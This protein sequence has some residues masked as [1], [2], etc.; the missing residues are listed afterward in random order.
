MTGLSVFKGAEAHPRFLERHHPEYL[1]APPQN[2]ELEAYATDSL[3]HEHFQIPPGW[4]GIDGWASNRVVVDFGKSHHGSELLPDEEEAFGPA[5]VFRN[6][7]LV[8]II[9][10]TG[11][12]H[13]PPSLS[14]AFM[15]R[16]LELASWGPGWDGDDA[17]P[18]GALT[19]F[20][21]LTI[22]FKMSAYV[23]S[24]PSVAP[25]VD[26]TLILLWS[27]E[28]GVALEIVIEAD[29]RFPSYAM[30]SK[31]DGVVE[32]LALADDATLSAL[33]ERQG[34]YGDHGIRSATYFV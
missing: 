29:G 8:S 18:I 5:H 13:H 11:F 28:N 23:Y 6:A 1:Y 20:A 33:L 31:P 4:K 2:Y 7:S 15:A 21:A 17:D 24:E 22:A 12:P 3:H 10:G 32:E 16:L 9:G 14:E 27:F 19:A 25:M 34:E 26:G 30:L